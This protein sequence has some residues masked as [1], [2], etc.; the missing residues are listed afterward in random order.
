MPRVGCEHRHPIPKGRP[1]YFPLD[2]R[3]HCYDLG[4]EGV[5]N[6]TL[7][8]ER[9]TE[10]LMSH[11]FDIVIT[12]GGMDMYYL[13]AIKDGSK[14][15]F[16]FHFAID[17][18]KTTWAG[19]NP[20]VLQ[21]V[22]V[23]LIGTPIISTNAGGIPSLIEDGETGFLYP[24]S[25]PHALAFKIMNLAGNKEKLEKVSDNEYRV[26]HNRHNPENIARQI[27]QIYSQIIKDL[28]F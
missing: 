11:H 20:T 2:N 4:L 25:E 19:P 17:I 21:K 1:T 13:H 16:W 18:A 22:K 8:K 9:L 27:I 3:I 23:Q 12:M 10:F 14:K 15:I 28:K 26:S 6:R 7:L 24:Y 5:A